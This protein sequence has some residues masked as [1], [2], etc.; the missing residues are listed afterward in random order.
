[1][2][3]H[4]G[5]GTLVKSD[6]VIAILD[7]QML[8]SSLIMEEFLEKKKGISQNLAKNAIKSIVIT[9]KHIYFS[10]LAS[11]TLKRKTIQQ[12]ILIDE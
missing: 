7:K 10:P 8:Q 12:A 1:M 6:E 2:Y 11:A 3:L 9:D 4:V 5:G